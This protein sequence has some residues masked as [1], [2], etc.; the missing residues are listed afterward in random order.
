M[1]YI[2]AFIYSPVQRARFLAEDAVRRLTVILGDTVGRDLR[3]AR[4]LAYGGYNVHWPWRDDV[5]D[6]DRSRRPEDV[7]RDDDGGR[8]EVRLGDR[9]SRTR[10]RRTTRR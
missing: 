7:G 6:A 10:R 4:A 2:P 1:T 8:D 5:H 3:V 9:R